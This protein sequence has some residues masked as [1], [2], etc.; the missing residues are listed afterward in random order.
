MPQPHTDPITPILEAPLDRP[1]VVAQLGQSL[2]G[3]IATASGESRWINR[4]AALDHLHRLRAS[5]DAVLI[6]IGTALADDPQLNVRRC[7]L[8]DNHRQPARVVLD[9]SGRLPP[10]AKLLNNDGAQ[11]FVI[12]AEGSSAA[13]PCEQLILPRENGKIAPG[14]IV[15]RLFQLG[16]KRILVEGGAST[17]SLFIDAGAVDRLHLLVAP[18]IIGSGKTG[19]QLPPVDRLCDALRP[20]AN[21]HV[22]DDG[23]VL[24]DCDLR[25][26]H[27][28]LAQAGDVRSEPD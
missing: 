4:D 24:F 18:L 17:V 27:V 16:L 5:A 2:D 14:A 21:V 6:G 19:L 26:S 9:P 23:D 28:S 25:A 7:P 13:A 1:F 11:C 15:T 10:N 12:N 8:P 20:Q 3:R 22:L